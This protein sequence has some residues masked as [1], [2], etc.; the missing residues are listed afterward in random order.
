MTVSSHQL[1]R[2]ADILKQLAVF[3]GL[4]AQTP[5]QASQKK[6]ESTDHNRE[7]RPI[8]NEWIQY[9]VHR[10]LIDCAQKHGYNMSIEYVENLIK[11][12]KRPSGVAQFLRRTT[13][14]WPLRFYG[15]A[16]LREIGIRRSSEL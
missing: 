14:Y 11:K 12:Y 10:E 15:G 16:L 5:L 1:F 13:Y 7:I 4:N 8:K 2:D 9:Q 6:N 3:C